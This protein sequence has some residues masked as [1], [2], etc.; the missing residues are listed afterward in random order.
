VVAPVIGSLL[1]QSFQRK[2]DLKSVDLLY[3]RCDNKV[4]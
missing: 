2:K 3:F 4:N 1:S